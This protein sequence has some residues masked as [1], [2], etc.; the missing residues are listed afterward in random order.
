MKLLA[1][2]ECF[3]KYPLER[4][5]VEQFVKIMKEVLDDT[6]LSKRGE[7]VSDLVDL[8]YRANKSNKDTIRFED[9]TSFLIEHEIEQSGGVNS[10]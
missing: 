6:M 10:I 7:F 5:D 9:I 8:F 4:V 1:I 3:E 2:S